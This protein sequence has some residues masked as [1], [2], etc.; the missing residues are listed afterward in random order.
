MGV[1]LQQP[2]TPT[3]LRQVRFLYEAFRRFRPGVPLMELH[4]RQKQAKRIGIFKDFSK[5]TAAVGSADGGRTHK[6]SSPNPPLRGFRRC[7][8]PRTLR[9]AASTFRR[10]TGSCSWTVQRTS[11][12]TSTVWLVS[13]VCGGSSS[14]RAL[15][16]LRFGGWACLYFR[17]IQGRTARYNSAGKAMLILVPSEEKMVTA[18]AERRVN[19]VKS[20]V[21]A[22]SVE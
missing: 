20:E 18:L 11:R 2:T 19:L 13:A 14:R 6:H 8:L 4:G 17:V 3:A 10:S 21:R 7:S 15:S 9:R 16:S 1:I 12:P 22:G 5:K